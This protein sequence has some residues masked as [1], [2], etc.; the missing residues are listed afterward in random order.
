MIWDV[1]AILGGLIAVGL[2]AGL[3]WLGTALV[4]MWLLDVFDDA[5]WRVRARVQRAVDVRW[6]HE[7]RFAFMEGAVVIV[8][9]VAY[10]AVAL[11]VLVGGAIWTGGHL[12]DFFESPADRWF[13]A[14][15]ALIVCGLF[16]AFI[17]GWVLLARDARRYHS[18]DD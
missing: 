10:G 13:G 17:V 14:L 1:L 2:I 16:V 7:K 8:L 11:L 18:R 3:L 15:P 5:T 6:P 9:T 12:L 4:G